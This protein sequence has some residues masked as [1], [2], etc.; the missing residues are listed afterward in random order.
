MNRHIAGFWCVYFLKHGGVELLVGVI[1]STRV[2][3]A[4]GR[5]KANCYT[6]LDSQRFPAFKMIFRYFQYWIGIIT[7]IIISFG[8]LGILDNQINN[9]PNYDPETNSYYTYLIAGKIGTLIASDS[10]ILGTLRIILLFII[11]PLIIIPRLAIKI[12]T[13]SLKHSSK[14]IV[15][16]VYAIYQIMLKSVKYLMKT[17]IRSVTTLFSK[18]KSTKTVPSNTAVKNIETQNT[19]TLENNKVVIFEPFKWM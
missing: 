17:S 18:I 5:H 11:L 12:Y 7:I 8:I 9:T 3:L 14:F 15:K 19:P 16:I 2:L 4:R 1:W 13:Q 10:L 6:K